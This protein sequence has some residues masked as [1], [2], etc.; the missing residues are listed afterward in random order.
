MATIFEVFRPIRGNSSGLMIAGIAMQTTLYLQFF[1]WFKL[2][3]FE[4]KASNRKLSHRLMVFRERPKSEAAFLREILF[5]RRQFLNAIAKL[6][7]MWHLNLGFL[8]TGGVWGTFGREASGD[9]AGLSNG[10]AT[11]WDFSG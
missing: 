11:G 2:V 8:G 6:A 10:R 7:P 5:F 1:C 3:I 4:L 9:M